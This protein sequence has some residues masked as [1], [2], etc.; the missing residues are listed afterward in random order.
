MFTLR[1]IKVLETRH[2]M[3]SQLAATDLR[4]LAVFE[5]VAGVGG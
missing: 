2:I 3:L 1:R 4:A 5:T